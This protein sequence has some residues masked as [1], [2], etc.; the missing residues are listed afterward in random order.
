MVIEA[1]ARSRPTFYVAGGGT[2]G[3]LYPA[4]AVAD[5]LRRLLPEVRFVFFATQRALDERIVRQANWELIRQ[6][7]PRQRGA[8]WNW[9]GAVRTYRLARRA[10]RDRLAND[11][12]ITVIGT[13]GFASV[14]VVCEAHR[15]GVPSVLLNP[16]A[17]PGKANRALAA[18]A[19]VVF[20][21]WDE[22]AER[23]PQALGVKVCGCAIRSQ[24]RQADRLKGLQRFGLDP[25]R[26]TLLV[27]G[28]SQG[29]R[30]IN[31]AVVATL[32][33]LESRLDWQVLHLTGEA[34]FETVASASRQMALPYRVE[35]FTEH[36]ADALG[37]A[38]LVVSRAGAS[39][40]AE[41]TAV[42]RASILMPYPH[43][44]GRH[45][46]ANAR[47]LERQGACLIVHD[48][49]DAAIN[50]PLLRHA[51][52]L[53]MTRDD[54]RLAMAAAARNLGRAR[55]AE[56]IAENILALATARSAASRYESVKE[57]SGWTR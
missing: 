51:L 20:A 53:L 12:V 7:L 22:T 33:H 26:K 37:A 19:D 54:R 57:L 3:H 49:I 13:G 46:L 34:D 1:A 56:D 31:E 8:A 2:G 36:M 47:C 17:L 4:L 18:I 28:A 6:A 9:P 21:Q 35:R 44:R 27:T 48:A 15:A 16:D 10:C 50:A 25:R 30:T 55:A 45:Q 5:A 42:G 23:L 41:I 14:P 52:E 43:D 40:L 38:D 11:R 39:T 32:G 24:F 29:A